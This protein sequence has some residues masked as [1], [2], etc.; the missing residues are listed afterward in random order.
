MYILHKILILL[1][2]CITQ[3]S[4]FASAVTLLL[5]LR[6]FLGIVTLSLDRSTLYDVTD[7][8]IETSNVSVTAHKV[9]VICGSSPLF[10]MVQCRQYLSPSKIS[11][12]C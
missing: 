11:Y 1:K 6:Y 8:N 5:Y 2:I 12:W 10:L 4:S 9:H 3:N 7:D